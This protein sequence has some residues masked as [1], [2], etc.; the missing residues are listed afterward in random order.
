MKIFNSI[1]EKLHRKIFGHEMSETMRNFIGNLSWSFWGTLISASFF[2]IINIVAGRLLGPAE[3]GKYNFVLSI[4]NILSVPIILGLDITSIHFITNSKNSEEKKQYLSNSFWI[5]IFTSLIFWIIYIFTYKFFR[6]FFEL[7]NFYLWIIAF[8]PIILSLK[9]LFDSFARSYFLFKFQSILKISESLVVSIFFIIFFFF[10]HFQ[11]SAYYLLSF[12]IGGIFI[13]AIYFLNF[14]NNI[15]RW[16]T[17]NFNRIINYSKTT[18]TII[19]ITSI[20]IYSDKIFIGKFLSEKELGFFSAYLTASMVVMMQFVAVISNIFFPLMNQ[21]VIKQAV[22]RKIDKLSF[23]FCIPITLIMFCFSYAILFL[24]GKEFE[25]NLFYILFFSILAFLQIPINLY[26][27]IIYSMPENYAKFKK[28]S[29]L[30][31][32]LFFGGYSMLAIKEFS[33][34]RFVLVIYSALT[35]FGLVISRFGYDFNQVSKII[36]K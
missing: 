18:I 7:N 16:K 14:R 36:K 17:E 9:M 28:Y 21:G 6:D 23:I 35:I 13:I 5:V 34:F 32:A 3:Y 22:V 25:A 29:F 4:V 1:I 24:F 20:M 11:E 19:I 30:H 15:I 2:A 27:N 31:L 8:F 33:N 12:I 26:R 10:L